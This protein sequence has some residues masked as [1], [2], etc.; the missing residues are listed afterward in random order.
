MVPICICG[1]T[2]LREVT[3][4]EENV[5]YE[6]AI[7]NFESE[8]QEK[9]QEA[10]LLKRKLMMDENERNLIYDFENAQTTSDNASRSGQSD[11]SIGDLKTT[12]ETE[13]DVEALKKAILE[14]LEERKKELVIQNSGG[15][16]LVVDVWS[17]G[18]EPPWSQYKGYNF[19]G[20]YNL[21]RFLKTMQKKAGLYAHLCIGPYVCAER[22]FG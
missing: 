11:E 4:Q 14:K 9:I 3:L 18:R 16:N 1:Q 12:V 2:Q 19:K 15:A 8:I 21:V 7:S 6:G 22:N 20:R 13:N 5:V 17:L 10:D